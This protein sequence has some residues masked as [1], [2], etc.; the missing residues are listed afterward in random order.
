MVY[1]W[2]ILDPGFQIVSLI[3]LSERLPQ[4]KIAEHG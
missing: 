1:V 3:L 4:N 2:L